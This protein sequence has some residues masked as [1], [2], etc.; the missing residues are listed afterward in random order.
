MEFS[1]GRE[2]EV[3]IQGHR[4]LSSARCS[5]IVTTVSKSN[6]LFPQRQMKHGGASGRSEGNGQWSVLGCLI[7]ARKVGFPVSSS[8]ASAIDVT[9][10]PFHVQVEDDA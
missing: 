8:T 5:F 4:P 9:L 10:K 1:W 3:S 7:S 2:D 6:L